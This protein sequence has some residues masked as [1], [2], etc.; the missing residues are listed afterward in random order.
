[1]SLQ[2]SGITVTVP[3]TA[4]PWLAG[5]ANGSTAAGGDSAPNQSP[6]MLG[7]N[8]GD[9][10]K[11]YVSGWAGYQPGSE[12]GPDGDWNGSFGEHDHGVENGIGGIDN[13]PVNALVGVF[14]DDSTPQAGTEP[15]A[16]DYSRVSGLRDT[17]FQLPALK[18]P[19]FIGNGVAAGSDRQSFYVPAGATRLFLGVMDGTGWNNNTGS[20]KVHILANPSLSNIVAWGPPTTVSGP[21]DVVKF[22]ASIMARSLQPAGSGGPAQVTVNNVVFTSLPD[23]NN[24][25]FG[26]M[27]LDITGGVISPVSL[28]SS[29]A[30]FSGL[31]ASYKTLLGNGTTRAETVSE[32]RRLQLTYNSLTVGDTYTFQFWVNGSAAGLNNFDANHYRTVIKTRSSQVELDPNSTN[33]DGGVGQHVTATFVA[34]EPGITF[35]FTAED[36]GYPILNAFQIRGDSDAPLIVEDRLPLIGGGFTVNGGVAPYT[37]SIVGGSLPPGLALGSDGQITGAYAGTSSGTVTIRV[38]DSTNAFSEKTFEVNLDFGIPEIL[39]HRVRVTEAGGGMRSAAFDVSVG[40]DI[41]LAPGDADPQ[42]LYPAASYAIEYRHRI[43]TGSF[44]PWTEEYYYPSTKVPTVVFTPGQ[45][46]QVELRAV[47]AAGNRGRVTAYDLGATIGLST[48]QPGVTSLSAPTTV[49]TGVG[50]SIVKLFAEDFDNNGEA[51]IVAVDRNSGKISFARNQTPGA[52]MGAAN[53]TTITVAD[54][55]ILDAAT[56]F[57]RAKSGSTPDKFRDLI[58]VTSGGIRM[59]TGQGASNPALVLNAI[60]AMIVGGRNITRVAVGDVNGDG[61]DDIIAVTE[62]LA[63]EAKLAVFHSKGGVGFETNPVLVDVAGAG[64]S[65]IDC[66]DINGDGVAD[67]V[68]AGPATGSPAAE[69]KLFCYLGRYETGL[70]FLGTTTDIGHEVVTLEIAEYTRHLLG[71]KDVLVGTLEGPEVL[72]YPQASH[73]AWHRVLVHQGEGVFKAAPARRLAAVNINGTE[74]GAGKDVFNIAVGSLTRRVLPDVIGNSCIDGAAAIDSGFLLPASSTGEL[75]WMEGD[76]HLITQFG[77][78]LSRSRRVALGDVDNDGLG[79]DVVTADFTDGKIVIQFNRNYTGLDFPAGVTPSPTLGLVKPSKL[80]PGGAASGALRGIAAQPW[81]FQLQNNNGAWTSLPGGLLAKSGTTVKTIVPRVPAGWLRF[82]CVI[83]SPGSGLYDALSTP[84]PYVRSLDSQTLTVTVKAEPDSDPAGNVSTHDNEFMTYRLR[85]ANT[86]TAPAQNVVLAAAIPTGTTWGNGGSAGYVANHPDPV[87]V[88]AVSWNLGTLNPGETGEKFY[89]VQVKSNALATLKTKPIELQSMPPAAVTSPPATAALFISNTASNKSF[90]IYSSAP[91]AG[92]KP[93]AATGAAVSTPVVPPLT[94]TQVV[95]ASSVTPGSLIDVEII[96]RNYGAGTIHNIKVEDFIEPSFVVEGVRLRASP[97]A[98]TGNFDDFLDTNPFS[99]TNPSLQFRAAGRFLSWNVGTLQGVRNALN[100]PQPPGECR[101]R[102]R[103]RIRYDVEPQQLLNDTLVA[104]ELDYGGLTAAGNPQGTTAVSSARVDIMPRVST[105][106][107]ANPSLDPPQISFVQDVVPLAGTN[108]AGAT[109]PANRQEMNVNG[110]DMA[111]VT[112]G[113][114]LRVKLRYGNTGG[115]EAKRC[116]ISYSVPT[117]AEFLGFV[118]LDGNAVSDPAV[119][120][121]FDGKGLLIPSSSYATRTKEGRSLIFNL[122]NLPAGSS[123]VVDFILA[124]FSPPVPKPAN[125][126]ATPA[127]TVIKSLAYTMETDSLVTTVQGSPLQVPVFVARPVSFDIESRPDQAQIVQTVGVAQIARFLISFRNNGWTPASNVKVQA[128]VPPGTVLISSQRLN[129]DLTATGISG[130][131]LSA[132]NAVVAANLARKV[133]FDVGSLASGYEG[134]VNAF[135]YAEI[136]VQIPSPLPTTFPKDG[137]LRQ[138]SEITGTDGAGKRAQGSYSLF[139]APAAD[140]IKPVSG[141]SLAEIKFIPSNARL[142][143]GKQ[144]PVIVRPGQLF[145]VIVFYGNTG[146]I[147][148]TNVK[149][150]VQVPW[151][152]DFVSAGTTPGFTKFSDKDAVSGKSTPNVYRWTIPTVAGHSAGAVTMMVR[153]KNNSAYEGKYLYENSAVVTGV[154]G[155]TTVERVPGNARMLVLST[156]PVASAWQWFGAQLQSIGSNLFG[157]GS[158]EVRDAVRGIS[159]S[160]NFYTIAGADVITLSNNVIIIPLLGGNVVAAGGGNVVASGGGNIV[161]SGGGN[162]VASGGGNL[163]SVTG[164]GLL[165]TANLANVV[166]GIVA[167]GGGNIVASGGG[168]LIANDGAGLI[169]ND[170]ASLGSI[171]PN[172]AGIVAAGGGNIVASGGGNVVAAGG[173]NVVASGG[174]NV[175]ENLASTRPGSALLA[176]DGASI[177]QINSLLANDG[178]SLIANDG[179]GLLANDGAGLIANDGAGLIQQ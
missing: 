84:S 151:G 175:T 110:E 3:G 23:T 34:Q 171:F 134:N 164:P 28:G 30:P 18:Q 136:V 113:G 64:L 21:A 154:V 29:Q 117:G 55:P 74:E 109:E 105:T 177:I 140:K 79:G 71:Q 173:G 80:V 90:G 145:P 176:N 148:L 42:T 7:V 49:M 95:S 120:T 100:Q 142:F 178:G 98:A 10:L 114:L 87:K 141:A 11:F 12:S 43:G 179:A 160:S 72:T 97:N 59:I 82:R 15:E 66:D 69:H 35:E 44:S 143:A 102:Y 124:A 2:A 77:S 20:F 96:L 1:L 70:S 112:E 52:V 32:D 165:T 68:V 31:N 121:L 41:G 122:G 36:G 119:Y 161:A 48:P 139:S 93:Q 115:T 174:G 152:T 75:H 125:E 126:K 116:R 163:I 167:S 106:V 162:I 172:L 5:A 99:T 40:D 13:A 25:G 22:D 50:S 26:S 27:D 132:S 8:D 135:G 47:D 92:F 76:D 103:L 45:K 111:V 73:I 65:A 157:Q 108:G 83:S 19:F 24:L 158:T 147:A 128:S 149:V 33:A 39:V 16:W 67:V 118:R 88:T 129:A 94:M 60:P 14:L 169:A 6:V 17:S 61:S 63:E 101:I 130:T 51:E 155:T 37:F 85:Y 81:D 127:G 58:V 107:A 137:R 56:G 166:A 138:R 168:N 153:V 156:N 89:F 38:T 150:A 131:P 123:G 9:E 57:L 146:D 86:G 133:E 144:L 62:K 91:A 46:V 170:G 53:F 159:A 78:D 4:N 54:A 104:R